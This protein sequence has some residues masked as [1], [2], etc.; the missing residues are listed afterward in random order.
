MDS[1][2]IATEAEGRMAIDSEAM[3]A[4]G[5]IALVKSNYLVNNIEKKQL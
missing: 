4:R 2:P 3:G 1:E 5:I